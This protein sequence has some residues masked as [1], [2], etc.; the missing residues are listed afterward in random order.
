MAVDLAVQIML[1]CRPEAIR[2]SQQNTWQ[3]RHLDRPSLRSQAIALSS[4]LKGE[5]EWP[6]NLAWVIVP[7]GHPSSRKFII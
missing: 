2:H 6:F 4:D 1:L 7:Q 3:T 5:A